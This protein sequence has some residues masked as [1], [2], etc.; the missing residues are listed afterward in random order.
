MPRLA[1][2]AAA[3]AASLVSAAPTAEALAPD[4]VVDAFEAALG[5]ITTARPSHPKGTCAA[6]TFTATPEG[7]RLVAAPVFSGKPIPANIRF[8]VAGASV[9]AASDVARSTR[10]L[11]FRLETPQG[12]I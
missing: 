1:L 6:G 2:A 7:T 4:E 5:P 8:G 11:S 12:D 9:R 10:G 3:F